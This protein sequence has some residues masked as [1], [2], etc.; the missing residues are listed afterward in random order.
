MAATQ[1][2]A[3]V[4]VEMAGTCPIAD[5][6]FPGISSP[7]PWEKKVLSSWDT[8][9]GFVLH[10]I[11]EQNNPVC[12][13]PARSGGSEIRCHYQVLLLCGHEVVPSEQPSELQTDEEDN[14]IPS[15]EMSDFMGG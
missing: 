14:L 8:E 5:K 11:C 12:P 13:R 15:L 2:D 3:N 9:S 10:I 6:G 4:F 1:E 7:G